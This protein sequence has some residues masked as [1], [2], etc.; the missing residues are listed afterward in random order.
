MAKVIT[1]SRHFPF[2]KERETYFVQSF[3]YNATGQ[4]D[5]AHTQSYMY[6]LMGLNSSKIV[7]GELKEADI[8]EFWESLQTDGR[9]FQKKHTIRVGHRFEAGEDFSPRVW[10]KIPYN[11]PQIIFWDDTK[12]QATY[13]FEVRGISPQLTKEVIMNMPYLDGKCITS[14]DNDLLKK[15]AMNDGLS[16]ADF[17][18][19]FDIDTELTSK[20]KPVFYGQI[21]CATDPIYKV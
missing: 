10:S 12:V 18:C 5:Y 15:I 4:H 1:Y 19:W 3:L 6:K 17:V 2:D 9:Y 14:P 13:E 16:V 8:R 21:I 20:A 7:T 11:S